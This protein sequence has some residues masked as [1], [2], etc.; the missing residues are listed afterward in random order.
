MRRFNTISVHLR[1]YAELPLHA[2]VTLRRNYNPSET[3]S[4]YRWCMNDHAPIS[5]AAN[6]KKWQNL[7]RDANLKI[8]I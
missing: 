8:K 5:N 6:A 2:K 3:L 1:K 4:L 7:E